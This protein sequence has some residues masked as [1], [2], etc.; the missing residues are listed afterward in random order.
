MLGETSSW[1][2]LFGLMMIVVAQAVRSGE[3]RL[4]DDYGTSILHNI[5]GSTILLDGLAGS[6]QVCLSVLITIMVK[7]IPYSVHV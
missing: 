5:H 4:R 6:R 7:I 3:F 1:R 2:V